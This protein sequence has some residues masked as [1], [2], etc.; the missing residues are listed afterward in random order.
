MDLMESKVA[1][2]RGGG[3]LRNQN[4]FAVAFGAKL[5]DAMYPPKGVRASL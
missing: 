1:G 4:W 3:A 2:C 5:S